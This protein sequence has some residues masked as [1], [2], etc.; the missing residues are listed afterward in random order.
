[1]AL[2]F[3]F[4]G[5]NTYE[6]A[7]PTTLT[8]TPGD[9]GE[10]E[11]VELN[12]QHQYE[13]EI[14]RYWNGALKNNGLYTTTGEFKRIYELYPSTAKKIYDIFPEQEIF[15][16]Y[17]YIY[18]KPI[19]YNLELMSYETGAMFNILVTNWEQEQVR[20]G[21]EKIMNYSI[22]FNDECFTEV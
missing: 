11:A 5:T 12:I 7:R 17:K 19:S 10:I 2:K 6:G 20:A 9:S 4:Y 16:K 15:K 1:M 3:R 22:L 21:S 13:G 18:L 8:G 14:I